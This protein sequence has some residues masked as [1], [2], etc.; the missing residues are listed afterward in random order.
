ML[1]E[2]LSRRYKRKDWGEPDLILIDGGRGQ[3]NIARRVL[4]KLKIK[5]P[6]ASIAK[7]KEEIFIPQ[8]NKPIKLDPNSEALKLIQKVRDEAHR[9]AIGYHKKLR[10][11]RK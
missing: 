9:F 8:K 11:K 5:I 2:V 1:K 4:K 10:S 7:R 3:L 6:V